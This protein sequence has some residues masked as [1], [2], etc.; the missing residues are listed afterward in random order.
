VNSLS[1]KSGRVSTQSADSEALR[2]FMSRTADSRYEVMKPSP[3]FPGPS[4]Q[5]KWYLLALGKSSE[6]AHR[7]LVWIDPAGRIRIES[8]YLGE[9]HERLKPL[10]AREE[11]IPIPGTIDSRS[12]Q[13][14]LDE[15][16]ARREIRLELGHNRDTSSAPFIVAAI[17]AKGLREEQKSDLVKRNLEG[18]KEAWEKIR[19]FEER[20]RK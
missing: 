6:I 16:S 2:Q 9:T 5:A 19:D 1:R 11:S 7:R 12:Y 14:V 13:S 20:A 15:V 17:D 10:D 18:L 3:E 8:M 4:D